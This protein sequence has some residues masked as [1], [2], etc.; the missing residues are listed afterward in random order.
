MA[1]GDN[2]D[3]FLLANALEA[4]VNHHQNGARG[5]RAKSQE[6]FLL[7]LDHPLC[8]CVWIIKHQLR[9]LEAHAM[10]VAVLPVL[11]F[12]PFEAHTCRSA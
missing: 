6:P 4:G 3:Y 2:P 12:V 11:F 8:K 5:N 9:R 7:V 1:G 10:F